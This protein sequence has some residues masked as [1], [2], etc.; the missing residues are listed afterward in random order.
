M[1]NVIQTNELNKLPT[2]VEIQKE[3]DRMKS[4]KWKRL[5]VEG[6]EVNLKSLAHYMDPSY[7]SYCVNVMVPCSCR[8]F[9]Y[10][11]LHNSFG[12]IKW[13]EI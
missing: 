7:F 8:L 10:I 4:C 9:T 13:V 12:G 6:D 2:L 1:V 5:E 11:I 3:F